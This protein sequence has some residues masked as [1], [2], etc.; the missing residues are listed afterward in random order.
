MAEIF[1]AIIILVY[2][3]D[4][5]FLFYYGVHTYA[6]VHLYFKNKESA[7][8]NPEQIKVLTKKMGKWPMVTVQLPMFNEYY[9]VERLIDSTIAMDYP[10][11]RLEIQV[12]DDSTDE[13]QELAKS[14]VAEY[15]AK[16]YNIK[17][18]HRI[19]RQGHK[20]GALREAMEKAKGEFIAIF[21]ADF[22]P[23]P[24]FLRK[25][26]PYFYESPKIGMVQTRWGHINADYSLLTKAQSIGIDGHFI[27]E[28]VARNGEFWMNFNGTAG[29]WRRETIYDAGNWE[30]DTLTEDF[31]LSYRAELKGWKFKYLSDIVNPAELP[32]T[33]PA[34]KSQQ[35][36][37]CKG[38]L[39]TAVKLTP[40]I[41]KADIPW[42]VKAEA[43]T[44]MTNYSVHPLMILN[45]LT[46][47]PLLLF[48]NRFE[49]VS[50]PILFF[51]AVILSVGTF[52]PLS[53]YVVSMREL[54]PKDWYRRLFWLPFLMMIGTG[55]AINNTRAWVEALIGKQSAFIRTPKLKIETGKDKVVQRK[56]YSAVKVDKWV[57]AELG[58][59]AYLGITMIVAAET[60]KA[61]VIPFLAIYAA[62]FLYV[63]FF[64][65]FDNLRQH[66]AN[67][68]ESAHVQ[69]KV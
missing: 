16:G 7:K 5:V 13:T 9:V 24:D 60:G 42:K 17:Y 31:D 51:I 21:D 41:L 27:I 57:F 58:L 37:W 38:S 52:G 49:S 48:Q 67:H 23:A 22:I 59:A 18:V 61:F 36:R 3:V 56:K 29:I 6:M 32:A 14:K 26:V 53:M 15:K 45:I 40:R 34:Y 8:T 35:F 46:T 19:N 62:G 66:L 39:Q 10:K 28:Q 12:V 4:I 43:F 1:F 20:A 64:T 47:L 11:N 63:S 55:I 33:V 2:F 30:S 44:H 54:H 68:R 50:L 69:H 25:T 65:L